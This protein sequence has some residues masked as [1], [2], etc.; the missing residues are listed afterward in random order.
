[1]GEGDAD[2]CDGVQPAMNVRIGRR[3]GPIGPLL[4]CVAAG[5]LAIAVPVA[6]L[7]AVSIEHWCC[8]P[9]PNNC[10]CPDRDDEQDDPCSTMRSCHSTDHVTTL[11]S[12]SSFAIPDLLAV[13]PRIRVARPIVHA[14]ADPRPSP[15]PHRPDAPS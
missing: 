8:C 4:A 7:T 14:I 11:S 1:M 13:A 12:I 5:I 3:L 15:P 10:H 6:Q 2:P 9:D